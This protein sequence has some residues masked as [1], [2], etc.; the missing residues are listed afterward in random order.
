MSELTSSQIQ[1]LLQQ[2][3]TAKSALEQQLS[4]NA[5]AS[6]PVQ[7]DQSA[8]GRVSRIDAIQQQH[9]AVSTRQQAQ[10]R[11][12]RLNAAIKAIDKEEYGYCQD[13]DEPINHKRLQVKP[14]ALL[15]ITCQQQR[16]ITS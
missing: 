11:L 14:E 16:D 13:C 1:E 5:S 15:C 10:K 12:V 2:M 3:Q 6:E 7:L 8:V 9:M 4:F